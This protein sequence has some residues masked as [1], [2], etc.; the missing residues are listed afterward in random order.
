MFQSVLSKELIQI[1]KGN[2]QTFDCKKGKKW[3]SELLEVLLHASLQKTKF[4]NFMKATN[5]NSIF[6]IEK[7][8]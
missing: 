8:L 3:F 2:Q 4:Q 7:Q 6:F 1:K 5:E